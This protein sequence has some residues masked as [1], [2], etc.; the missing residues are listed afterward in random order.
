MNGEWSVSVCSRVPA[1]TL[2]SI[3]RRLDCAC[4]FPAGQTFV[5]IL[6]NLRSFK[7]S[8]KTALIRIEYGQKLSVAANPVFKPPC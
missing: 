2:E 5:Q 1:N 4:G 6:P 8:E 7:F 3:V